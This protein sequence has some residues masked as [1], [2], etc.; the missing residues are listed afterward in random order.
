MHHTREVP[1]EVWSD[2][3]TLLSS[4]TQAQ[5]VRIEA[6]SLELGEQLLA[7]RLPLVDI[8]FEEKGSGKDTIE[9][10]VGRPGEE[11]T[12]RILH[13]GHIYADESESGELECLAIEDEERTKTLIFFEPAEA[14]RES[15]EFA[16][17]P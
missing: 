11:I 5:C 4:I 10:T 8:S 17:A 6:G 7:Q 13:P 15:S 1:R 2:Y 12:H 14:Y 3:L 9:V 16:P